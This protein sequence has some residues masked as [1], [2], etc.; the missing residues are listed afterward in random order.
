MLAYGE[1]LKYMLS[2]VILK[3][4]CSTSHHALT[5]PIVIKGN[6]RATHIDRQI[7]W[8]ISAREEKNCPSVAS[9][10]HLNLVSSE[11]IQRQINEESETVICY[12]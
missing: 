11:L 3:Q 9:T 5:D 10:R 7:Y 6:R 12:L 1:N 2:E 8:L 4:I